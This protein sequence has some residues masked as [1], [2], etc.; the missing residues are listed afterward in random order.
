MELEPVTRTEA[1]GVPP[2]RIIVIRGGL[3]DGGGGIPPA[4]YRAF[5]GDGD[6]RRQLTDVEAD[7][8][9]FEGLECIFEDEILGRRQPDTVVAVLEKYGAFNIYD[10][11]PREVSSARKREF[12]RSAQEAGLIQKQTFGQKMAA[13]LHR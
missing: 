10:T 5:T 8:V 3:F 7:A 2:R 6:W 1:A 9:I 12:I 13:M 4:F 11:P